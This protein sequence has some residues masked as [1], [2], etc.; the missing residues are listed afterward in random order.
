MLGAK[1]FVTPAGV[2]VPKAKPIGIRQR[3]RIFDRDG[4]RCVACGCAVVRHG[5]FSPWS[6]APGHVDH[7]VPRARGGQN[8]DA[9]LRVL[10]TTCNESKGAN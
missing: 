9:N 10:C 8:E 2:A 3:Y 7:I 5:R 1:F 6:V 4:D